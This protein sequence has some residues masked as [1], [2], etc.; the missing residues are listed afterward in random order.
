M[1]ELHLVIFLR[2][3]P[4]FLDCR[5]TS[6]AA[7][8]ADR[9]H[10]F[11]FTQP[12]ITS[13]PQTRHV[14]YYW[15][16]QLQLLPQYELCYRYLTLRPR[17]NLP[18]DSARSFKKPLSPASTSRVHPKQEDVDHVGLIRKVCKGRHEDKGK[19]TTIHSTG[20]NLIDLV[21][22]ACPAQSQI[23]RAHSRRDPCWR[24]RRCGN[25]SSITEPSARLYMDNCIQST[26]YCASDDTGRGTQCDL[27]VFGRFALEACNKQFL[28]WY[29][30]VIQ[31]GRGP[32]ANRTWV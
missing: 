28:R 31:D 16:T 3:L 19:Q 1:P 7:G 13:K 20:V 23:R 26:H 11:N 15:V 10:C 14:K 8:R 17:P 24:C 4:Q 30:Q 18:S 6:G 29:V 2:L 22:T 21:E 32:R 9:I 5:R 27:E 25:I 12:S